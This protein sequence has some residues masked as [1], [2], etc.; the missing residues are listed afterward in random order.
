MSIGDYE[1]ESYW[2]ER[3]RKYGHT[4]W[5]DNLIYAYDQSLRL[6][7]V[8]KALDKASITLNGNTRIL[9][10]G[11]GIGDFVLEFAQRGVAEVVGIDISRE[12]IEFAKKRFSNLRN[13]KLIHGKI[14]ELELERDYFDLV[15]S[16]TVLQHITDEDAFLRAID[17]IIEVT[18]SKGAILI[19]E[20][21]PIAK[22]SLRCS[23]YQTIRTREEWVNIFKERGCRPLYEAGIPQIGIRFLPHCSKALNL[24]KT[25]TQI[26]N[27]KFA[28]SCKSYNSQKQHL[29]SKIFKAFFEKYRDIMVSVDLLFFPFPS[30]FTNIRIIIFE[31]ALS[32]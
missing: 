15:V 22:K 17:N 1:P 29:I 5:S 8:S 2:D 24:V 16:I 23:S 18:K 3:F 19:L 9:D 26:L 27:L 12:V 11:C 30:N 25:G 32:L 6:K 21:S 31:K 7:A 20:A 14:E 13:V 28:K 10:V 4:G